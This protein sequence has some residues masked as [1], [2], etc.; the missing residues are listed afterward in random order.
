MHAY[1]LSILHQSVGTEGERHHGWCFGLP[2]GI[3]PEQWP[4]DLHHGFPLMHGFTLLLPDDYRVHGPEIVGLSF[5]STG[6]DWEDVYGRFRKAKAAGVLPNQDA[7]PESHPRLHRMTDELGLPYGVIL[8]SRQEFDGPFCAP[9]EPWPGLPVPSWLSDGSARA[10]WNSVYSPALD[11]PMEEYGVYRKLGEVPEKSLSYNRAIRWTPRAQDPNAG[12]APRSQRRAAETGY[13]PH[14]YYEAGVSGVETAESY[15]VHDWAK[16]HAPNHIGGT[17]SP[18]QGLEAQ[19]GF[20]PFYVEFE[21]YLGG[22]NFGGGN[23]QLDFRDMR[24][25]WSC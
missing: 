11:L 23:A 19:P 10:Y 18:V 16:D 7:V 21:E 24:F 12:H 8:L 9:P 15:R 6:P 22:Y 1:D 25:F 5:F 14:F 20:S 3:A 2:P 4:R 17:M 13:E